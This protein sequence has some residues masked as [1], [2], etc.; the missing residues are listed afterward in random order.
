MENKSFLEQMIKDIMCSNVLK[1]KKK[2]KPETYELWSDPAIWANLSGNLGAF[3]VRSLFSKLNIDEHHLFRWR[4]DNK[5]RQYQV[6]N[7]F[8]PGSVAKT[9]GFS[10][11][12]NEGGIN[13][14]RE[15]CDH[16]FFIKAAL[17]D[18]S[19]RKNTFDKTHLLDDI[20]KTEQIG[21]YKNEKW[22]LQERLNF[23]HEFRIHTFGR[24]LLDGFTFVMKGVNSL[25]NSLEAET[26]VKKVIAKLPDSILQGSLIGWDAGITDDHKVYIIEA[27][28]TGFHPEYH[29]GFQTSGY[30]GDALVGSAI[31]ALLNN[32]IRSKYN[33]SF[34][35]LDNYLLY[36]NVFFEEILYFIP[37]FRKE[38]IGVLGN[39]NTAPGMAGII[40]IGNEFSVHYF[41]LLKYFHMEQFAVTYYLIVH[42]TCISEVRKMFLGLDTIKII[43]EETLFTT[44][45]YELIWA[46]DEERRRVICSYHTLRIIREKSY[47]FI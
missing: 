30:F 16:G 35:T 3:F 39:K 40:Y 2:P 13:S 27:N 23:I 36:N 33:V 17:G 43:A 32:Y 14:I 38:H 21:T 26:F 34:N 37:K 41:A 42:A 24:D 6:F 15:L 44:S 19:G 8:Y 10:T 28:F 9:I 20:I 45:Q 11:L 12:F 46:L 29:A 18:S 22:I 4:L 7:H 31:C 5:Y 25:E 47:F 1:I